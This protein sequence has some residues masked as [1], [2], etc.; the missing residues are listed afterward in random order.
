MW[1][2]PRMR[3]SDPGPP[4]K[5]RRPVRG[6]AIGRKANEPAF[7]A[8]AIGLRS[9]FPLSRGIHDSGGAEVEMA[10]PEAS[11]IHLVSLSDLPATAQQ[12]RVA[13]AVAAVLILA[14]AISAPFANIQLSRYD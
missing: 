1:P 3:W 5:V 13:L 11:N 7:F 8:S 4:Q 12:R 14:F 10:T 9:N 2:F 6:P